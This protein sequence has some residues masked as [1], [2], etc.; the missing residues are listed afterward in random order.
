MVWMFHQSSDFRIGAVGS[1][2]LR[3]WGGRADEGLI[4]TEAR[5][6]TAENEYDDRRREYSQA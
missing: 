1:A 3:R 6:P 4:L 5:V 2:A